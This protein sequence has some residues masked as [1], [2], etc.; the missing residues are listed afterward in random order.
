MAR[1]FVCGPCGHPVVIEPLALDPGAPSFVEAWAELEE[2]MAVRF[3]AF[4]DALAVAL[5]PLGFIAYPCVEGWHHADL[6]LALH[7]LPS[8]S[9][10]MECGDGR[11]WNRRTEKR[12]PTL[13][14]DDLAAQVAD[15]LK[16]L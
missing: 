16:E 1:S 15:I 13:A 14:A 9:F 3:T 11:F 4:H 7:A 10:R 6:D 12:T 5:A 2:I 8:G